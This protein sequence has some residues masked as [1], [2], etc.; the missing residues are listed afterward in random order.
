[1]ACKRERRSETK[2]SRQTVSCALEQLKRTLRIPEDTFIREFT[3][4]LSVRPVSAPQ[5]KHHVSL[6]TSEPHSVFTLFGGRNNKIEQ[7][8]PFGLFH[9]APANASP[10]LSQ[11]P[12]PVRQA[13]GSL[14][15][16]VAWATS[17]QIKR[18]TA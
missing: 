18:L 8:P 6:W 11:S 10:R 2:V 9:L 5:F 7:W 14:H 15:E 16:P 1:M 12:A 4:R 13:S 3:L 17:N